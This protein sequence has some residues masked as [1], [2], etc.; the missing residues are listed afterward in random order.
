[1]E[2]IAETHTREY[3]KQVMDETRPAVK[4]LYFYFADNPCKT[5]EQAIEQRKRYKEAWQHL[6][7]FQGRYERGENWEV[8]D[9]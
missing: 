7:N 2:R 4:Y 1:M 6:F 9:V 8:C 5:R 3:W